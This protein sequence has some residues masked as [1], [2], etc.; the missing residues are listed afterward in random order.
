[1]LS[2]GLDVVSGHGR[3][4]ERLLGVEPLLTDCLGSDPAECRE[5]G[6]RFAESA[7]DAGLRVQVVIGDEGTEVV[8]GQRDQHGIDELARPAGAIERFTG[9]S[10]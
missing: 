3:Q 5:I 6:E 2:D 10:R 1:M 7:L 4:R 8:G 9:V